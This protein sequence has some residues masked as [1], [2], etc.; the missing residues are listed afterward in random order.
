M[1]DALPT[2]PIAPRAIRRLWS[3]M[4]LLALATPHTAS[5]AADIEIAGV[6]LPGHVA[7][8]SERLVLN[9]AGQ[10]SLWGFRIY[11]AALYLPEPTH[12]AATALRDDLPR[13]LEITLQRDFSTEQNLDALKDGLQANNPSAELDALRHETEQFL[14]LLRRVPEVR[15][16]T[17]IQLDYLP[18]I[19]TR[20]GIGKTLLGTIAGERFNRA[21]MRIWLGERPI[22]ASLKK[23]LLGREPPA[24]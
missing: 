5:H 6:H 22:Q 3:A 17:T 4:L 16:G 7:L 12:D 21:L 9:G 19:G 8:A 23:A 1:P 11:V 20:V 24:L 14:G 15:K 18:G 13:R 2:Q 10:R